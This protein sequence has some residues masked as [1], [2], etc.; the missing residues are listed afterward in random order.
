[1]SLVQENKGLG[2]VHPG[3]GSVHMVRV[4]HDVGYGA[5]EGLAVLA[6]VSVVVA[7]LVEQAVGVIE[8]CLLKAEVIGTLGE[9]VH[10][11]GVDSEVH[12]NRVALNCGLL[13]ARGSSSRGSGSSGLLSSVS[14]VIF[15]SVSFLGMDGF[16]VMGL[17]GVVH[18]EVLGVV[19][20]V[21]VVVDND[22]LMSVDVLDNSEGVE[23]DL[24]GDLVL[25]GDQDTVLENLDE[26][27]KVLLD[28]DLVPV[29]ADTG[30]GDREALLLVRSLDL[31]LH[32]AFLEESD[33]QIEVSSAEFH[34]VREVLVLVKVEGAVDGILVDDKGI[35]LNVVSGHQVVGAVAVLAVTLVL[36]AREKLGEAVAE[37]FDAAGL[38]ELRAELVVVVVTVGHVGLVL[39]VVV[40]M[41]GI[42]LVVV[43]LGLS[44]VVVV[45]ALML[46]GVGVVTVGILILVAVLVGLPTVLVGLVS[47][48]LGLVVGLVVGLAVLGGVVTGLVVHLVAEDGLE[49][50]AMVGEGFT[51]SVGLHTK[52]AGG[53]NR[54]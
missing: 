34:C 41:V 14:V 7:V 43:V 25:A 11:G 38:I 29:D 46:D 40:V 22:S 15:R 21:I 35:G 1:M 12:T 19:V 24:V 2:G 50:H 37:V 36:V 16:G 4:T 48:I 42:V 23:L 13:G 17:R 54:R 8:A 39:S 10:V 27:V 20:E 44:V 9:T 51:G 31:Y 53:K 32:D 33:V 30:V 26:V 52:D 5:V 45:L 3:D 18:T 47:L 28:L 6:L 49:C